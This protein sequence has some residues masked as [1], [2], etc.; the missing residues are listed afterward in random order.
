MLKTSWSLVSSCSW[1]IAPLPFG[2]CVTPLLFP[3][4]F[5]SSS[6]SCYLLD[7]G[8]NSHA[9]TIFGWLTWISCRYVDIRKQTNWLPF[10]LACAL[11]YSVSLSWCFPVCDQVTLQIN[12]HTP[13]V[14]HISPLSALR[15]LKWQVSCSQLYKWL[16]HLGTWE[17][18][19]TITRSH[20]MLVPY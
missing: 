10:R 6:S 12:T 2:I 15:S 3:H 4:L 14:D 9:N 1:R 5:F 8:I 11:R 16:R 18:A 19:D 7:L 17:G 20:F 13:V